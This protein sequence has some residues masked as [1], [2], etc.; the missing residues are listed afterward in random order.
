MLTD[1][2]SVFGLVRL[3]QLQQLHVLQM[4]MAGMILKRK[5]RTA[6]EAFCTMT[7]AMRSW[8]CQQ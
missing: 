6:R 5:V 7:Y 4:N 8:I 3:D 2:A 1:N